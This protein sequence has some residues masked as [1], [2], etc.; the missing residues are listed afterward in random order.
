M[1]ETTDSGSARVRPLARYPA[2]PPALARGATVAG[3]LGAG[4]PAAGP[5]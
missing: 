3:L 2:V 4:H 5:P 1:N